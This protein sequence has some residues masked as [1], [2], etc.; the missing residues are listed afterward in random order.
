MPSYTT[1]WMMV[2]RVLWYMLTFLQCTYKLVSFSVGCLYNYPCRVFCTHLWISFGS[3]RLSIYYFRVLQPWSGWMT[4]ALLLI[5][6]LNYRANAY[7][8]T[9]NQEFLQL[10]TNR[11]HTIKEQGRQNRAWEDWCDRHK[12]SRAACEQTRPQSGVYLVSHPKL[13]SLPQEHEPSYF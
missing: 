5:W 9:W 2:L 12:F 3:E 6:F 4:S 11:N 7:Y 10:G 13:H 1:N 8:S